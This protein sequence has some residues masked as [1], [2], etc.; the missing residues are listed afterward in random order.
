[1]DGGD[2]WDDTPGGSWFQTAMHE[3]GHLLGL[4][5]AAELP[6]VTI[7]SGTSA[8]GFNPGRLASINSEPDFPGDHDIAH[9]LHLHRTDSIDVDRYNFNVTE[10][11][12]FTVE[13]MAERLANSSLL[14]SK[15]ELYR[16]DG[17]VDVLVAQNDDYF[18]ED[19]FIELMLEPGDYAL[20]V[21]STDLDQGGS[22]QGEYTLRVDF[23]ESVTAATAL[24][25]AD[26][27]AEGLQNN[28]LFDGDNDGHAGGVYNFWFNAA[29]ASDTLFVDKSAA[30]GGDGS[31][32]TPFNEIDVALAAATPG[33]IVRIVGNDQGDDGDVSNDLPYLIGRDLNGN[34]LEDGVSLDVPQGVTVMVDAGAIFKLR[35]SQI[36]VG[37]S[38]TLIDRSVGAL[39]IL[40]KPDQQVIFTSLLDELVG[41]DTTPTPTTA[42]PGNW[43]G[44]TFRND[45]DES[46]GRFSY[47]KEGIFIDHIGQASIRYGGGNAVVDSVVQ[48]V[49]PINMIDAQ[50]TIT[51]N[52]ITLSADS[53]V[54][55]NPDSFEQF[56][57]HSPEFQDGAPLFTSD[58]QR[59]GPDLAFNTLTEN[60]TNG[61]FIKV[62]TLAGSDMRN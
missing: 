49:N 55:A 59:V 19:S 44:I 48:P 30:A 42:A 12:T 40:G 15:L 16:V 32:A 5:H 51:Y 43:G 4:G 21:S 46:Q 23:K 1:M 27:D 54:A 25:D 45:A 36:G 38:S 60:S 53:A 26:L 31:I 18:S 20:A 2:S 35:Q 37:S 9:G 57:F 17:G 7:M 52:E 56:T 11:G 22:S 62:S 10:A 28:T 33:Q 61:L 47:R 8:N 3:I 34:V 6:P 13:V 14:D 58:Y 41:T 29:A 39:Q 50:P 24:F